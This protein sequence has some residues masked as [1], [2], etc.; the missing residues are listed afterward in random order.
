MI[1]RWPPPTFSPLIL[2]MLTSILFAASMTYWLLVRRWTSRRQWVA[3]ADWNREQGFK[4][5]RFD[6]GEIPAPL[7]HISPRPRIRFC[8]Q[9]APNMFL[10]LDSS[11]SLAETLNLFVRHIETEL[12]PA[13]LHPVTAD[14]SVIRLFG[15]E[16][17]P[18]LRGADRFV[19]F[20]A[21]RSA[22]ESLSKSSAAALLPPDVALLLH[23]QHMIL[24]FSARPFDAIEFQRMLALSDQIITHLPI[25]VAAR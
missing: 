11:E 10:Q 6:E 16:P 24:D 9:K 15:M 21:D 8:L 12:A 22:A 5:V 25:S 7:T 14:R 3:L 19:T 4:F 2:L 20:G 18:T 1:A 13:G 17:F 23:G